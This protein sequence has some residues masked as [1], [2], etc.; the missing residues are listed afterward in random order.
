MLHRRIGHSREASTNVGLAT[1]TP[2][3]ELR[4]S[5]EQEVRRVGWE[6]QAALRLSQPVTRVGLRVPTR[7]KGIPSE[8]AGREV[9]RHEEVDSIISIS[10]K[11]RRRCNSRPMLM[12]TGT[13]RDPPTTLN[14]LV[15]SLVSTADTSHIT[16]LYIDAWTSAVSLSLITAYTV[17]ICKPEGPNNDA[18]F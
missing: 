4:R 2:L 6:G 13:G 18:M 9:K 5:Q 16:S 11:L 7:T 1:R 17:H 14:A 12:L 10:S 8:A 15:M 3:K